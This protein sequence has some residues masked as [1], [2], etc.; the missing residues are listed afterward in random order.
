MRASAPPY[1]VVLPLSVPPLRS[2]V[3]PSVKT[4]PP[5]PLE[6]GLLTVFLLRVPP[7]IVSFAGCSALLH[8]PMAPPRSKPEF[9][10]IVPPLMVTDP[11]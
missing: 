5:K 10:L 6:L 8:T 9:W 1:S 7:L 11:P 4:A 2:T 3:A